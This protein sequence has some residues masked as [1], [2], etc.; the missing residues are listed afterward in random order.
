MMDSNQ[1]IRMM[2]R[3]SE[4]ERAIDKVIG[5]NIFNR[6]ISLGISQEKLAGRIGITFQQIQKY[7]KGI[8]R[9]SSSRLF[10]IARELVTTV[11]KLL[12]NDEEDRIPDG[13]TRRVL[14][15]SRKSKDLS[16]D[17]LYV[18]SQLVNNLH[19]WLVK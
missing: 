9:T 14:E 13:N 10:I 19:S 8:D 12:P 4:E 16:S 11:S 2:P 3:G 17:A 18:V 15:I 6:R 5:E 7:E 1:R